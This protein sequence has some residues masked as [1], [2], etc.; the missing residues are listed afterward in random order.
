M[1]EK[2]KPY[3]ASILFGAFGALM[4]LLGVI[5]VWEDPSASILDKLVSSPIMLLISAAS[6]F[7]AYAFRPKSL[8]PGK[9]E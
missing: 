2:I 4:G 8:V 1:I 5:Q 6:V 9:V 3:F 7:A